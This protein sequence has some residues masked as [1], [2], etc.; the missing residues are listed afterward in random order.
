MADVDIQG[1]CA[2]GFERVRDAFDQNFAVR[3]EVGAAVAV[4]V[5]GDLVVDLWGGWADASRS[6]PWRRSHSDRYSIRLDSIS[7][8]PPR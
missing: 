2:S 7:V 8:R 1:S 4:Y 5:D 3:D 6:R